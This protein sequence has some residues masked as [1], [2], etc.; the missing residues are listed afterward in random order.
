[1]EKDGWIDLAESKDVK[2]ETEREGERCEACQL[3]GWRDGRTA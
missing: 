3:G 2:R 1:M